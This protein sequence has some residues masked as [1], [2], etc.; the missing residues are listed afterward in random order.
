MAVSIVVNFAV[1]L[2]V[3]PASSSAEDS[4]FS[5]VFQSKTCEDFKACCEKTCA[6]K[7]T[8]S[9]CLNDQ[10]GTLARLP[11]TKCEC[12]LPEDFIINNELN[13]MQ[14]VEMNIESEKCRQVSENRCDWFNFCCQQSCPDDE[15]HA[16]RCFNGATSMDF[17]QNN[18]QC[19]CV[20]NFKAP[21]TFDLN[22]PINSPY[23]DKSEKCMP[24]SFNGSCNEFET[25]CR[26]LCHKENYE[27]SQQMCIRDSQNRPL[28]SLLTFCKCI[29]GFVHKEELHTSTP[30]SS[31]TRTLSKDWLNFITIL[32]VICFY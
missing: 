17:D 19:Y 6:K 2:A 25:C 11:E 21:L 23:D 26:D 8:E 27:A 30:S 24:T 14:I 20:K 15:F 28:R 3:L 13:S 16:F 10:N 9:F 29:S 1:L 31:S 5:C 12:K 22:G 4:T 7:I 32:F 18:T